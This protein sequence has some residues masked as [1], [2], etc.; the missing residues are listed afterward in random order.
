MYKHIF[1]SKTK[2]ASLA[3]APLTALA[4]YFG[5]VGCIAL[6]LPET[7][8]DN[9]W[10]PKDITGW[11]IT[12][13]FLF[14]TFYVIYHLFKHAS[15]MRFKLLNLW[16]L[17]LVII[18]W[19]SLG[20]NWPLSV[21]AAHTRLRFELIYTNIG[22]ASLGL[23]IAT[24]ISLVY[25][26]PKMKTQPWWL[27]AV[28]LVDAMFLPKLVEQY[29]QIAVVEN[30]KS[31]RWDVFAQMMRHDHMPLEMLNILPQFFIGA[32]ITA[33]ILIGGVKL[34]GTVSQAIYRQEAKSQRAQG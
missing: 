33:V 13:V 25:L 7:R 4:L 14:A 5:A 19:I 27:I 23:L 12:V 18:A 21:T 30:L 6:T 17:V 31:F 8:T 32:A 28:L 11:T 24:I 1:L 15:L 2:Q 29:N 10:Q 16:A 9:L 34:Y 20:L 22:V 26:T 3:I